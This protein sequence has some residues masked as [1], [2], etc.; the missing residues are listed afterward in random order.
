MR[1]E[2]T[3]GIDGKQLC[4]LLEKACSRLE[5]LGNLELFSDRSG[6][7]IAAFLRARIPEIQTGSIT[8]AHRT[9]VWRIF[10]PTGEW[11]DAVGDVALGNAVFEVVDRLFRPRPK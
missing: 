2:D 4:S 9:E 11:D 6:P 1:S 10:A 7:A 5:A 8:E 3:S